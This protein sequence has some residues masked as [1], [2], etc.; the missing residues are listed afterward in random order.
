MHSQ[1]SGSRRLDLKDALGVTPSEVFGSS[2]LESVGTCVRNLLHEKRILLQ[3]WGSMHCQLG[4]CLCV[5]YDTSSHTKGE[6]G[7]ERDARGLP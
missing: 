1:F 3:W 6:A 5:G 7:L 2:Q 4:N